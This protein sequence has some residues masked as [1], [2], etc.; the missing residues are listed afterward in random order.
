MEGA[1]KIGRHVQGHMKQATK[2][3]WHK[4]VEALNAKV[5]KFSAVVR[6]YFET[7]LSTQWWAPQFNARF[8]AFHHLFCHQYK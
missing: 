7:Y 4:T 1:L 8:T 5:K 2:V 6:H 3:G